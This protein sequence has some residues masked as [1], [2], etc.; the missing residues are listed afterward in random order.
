[1]TTE[2]SPNMECII[3]FLSDLKISSETSRSAARNNKKKQEEEPYM[4]VVCMLLSKSRKDLSKHIRT[5]H[6][7]NSKEICED[8]KEACAEYEK[9]PKSTVACY[10]KKILLMK[11]TMLEK[12][13]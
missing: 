8:Y 4:C 9:E 10:N 12:F 13:K 7:A 2:S 6:K 1:M 3:D 11:V 5:K